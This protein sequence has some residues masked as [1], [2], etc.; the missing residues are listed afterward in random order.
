VAGGRPCARGG[1]GPG[2]RALDDED[3]LRA[4]E[5]LLSLVGE[6]P[7]KEPGSGLIEQ[8]RRFAALDP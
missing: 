4:A 8:Q 2:L 5:D 3:A 7:G 1:P 6:L